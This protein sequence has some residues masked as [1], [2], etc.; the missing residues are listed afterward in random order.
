MLKSIADENEREAVYRLFGRKYDSLGNLLERVSGSQEGG[1]AVDRYVIYLCA[2]Q[3]C[4][5]VRAEAPDF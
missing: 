1:D 3:L 4:D 2:K 5:R